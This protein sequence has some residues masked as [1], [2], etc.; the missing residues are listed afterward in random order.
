M[1][2]KNML[3]YGN[4]VVDTLL[5]LPTVTFPTLG[6]S[7]SG[8]N[9][10]VVPGLLPGDFL[11]CSM[12]NPPAHIFLD[13]AYVSSNN[14]VT[15]TWST[16]GTGVST[17]TVAVILNVSRPDTLSLGLTSLPAALV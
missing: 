10:A 1:P 5:Y 14:T 8:T 4:M 9:T 13:N 16:D 12:Q 17:S 6:A 2:G 11:S 15:F 3:A 7:V